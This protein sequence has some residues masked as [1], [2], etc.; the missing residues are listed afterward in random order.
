M[1]V[2]INKD[3]CCDIYF[4]DDRMPDDGGGPSAISRSY[5]PTVE[6]RGIN[7]TTATCKV[8][9]P[10]QT[11]IVLSSGL[12]GPRHPLYLIHPPSFPLSPLLLPFPLPSPQPHVPP[13]PPSPSLLNNLHILYRY[14]YPYPY[15]ISHTSV[16]PSYPINPPL[17]NPAISIFAQEND[18]ALPW[19]E[20]QSTG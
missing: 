13:S 3:Y 5:L 4:I 20:I 12:A 11:C 16:E 10:R 17:P 14:P 8:T 15:P 18:I 9:A 1:R 7:S 6:Y 19:T 2:K